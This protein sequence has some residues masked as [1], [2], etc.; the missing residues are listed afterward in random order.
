MADPAR[1]GFYGNPFEYAPLMK[2]LAVPPCR[3]R[4]TGCPLPP[5]VRMVNAHEHRRNRAP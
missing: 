5:A 3:V 1:H 2:K 4:P